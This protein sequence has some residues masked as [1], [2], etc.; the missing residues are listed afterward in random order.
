[1]RM[2]GDRFVAATRLDLLFAGGAR[3]LPIDHFAA[4]GGLPA[5]TEPLASLL[6]AITVLPVFHSILPSSNHQIERS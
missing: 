6:L 5:G 3:P 4:S 1:M 2:L